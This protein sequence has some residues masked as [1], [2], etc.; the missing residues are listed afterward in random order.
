MDQSTAT[1]KLSEQQKANLFAFVE[2]KF[3]RWYDVQC[4]IVEDLASRIMMEMQ[5]DRQVTFESALEK[6]YKSFGIFGFAKVVQEKQVE[7]AANAK[8]RWWSEVRD[9]LK[10]PRIVLI[11]LLV[12]IIAIISLSL[13][14][15]MLNGVFLSIYMTI[16][17][18]FFIYVMRDTGL[19]KR[20]LIMQSGAIYVSIPFIYEFVVFSN[21]T[22]FTSLTFTIILSMG[23]L[24]K[25]TSFKL[26]RSVR[27][28]AALL[29]PGVFQDRKNKQ[30]TPE[31]PQPVLQKAD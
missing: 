13:D 4:E 26:Y 15:E 24:M 25:L 29:Y 5:S 19:H 21:F 11:L 17:I 7:L 1:L 9:L 8:K 18:L 20:L 27:S 30:V 16:S 3:V 10:W 31:Q 2:K 23:I 14:S 22:Q 28:E 12:F 6:V